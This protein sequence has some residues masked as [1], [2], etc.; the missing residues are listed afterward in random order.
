MG[1]RVMSAAMLAVLVGCADEPSSPATGD[2]VFHGGPVLTI[3]DG[4]AEAL[5]VRG[6]R[7]LAVGT[8]DQVLRE[9]RDPRRVDLGGAALLPGFI[10]GHT[11]LV[12]QPGRQG[13]SE[14]D[15]I[16]TALRLGITTVAET[17]GWQ[18]YVD[19]LLALEAGGELRVRVVFYPDYNLSGPGEEEPFA[20]IGTWYPANP[21]LVDDGRRLRISGI[22][23]FVDG[24]FSENRGC[25]ALTDPYPQEAQDDPD[26][27]CPDP[28]GALL[29]EAAPLADVLVAAEEAG[30]A[31]AMHAIGDRALDHAL[32]ALEQARARTG[33]PPRPHQL[34]HNFF[35]RPDQMQRYLDLDV[36]FSVWAYAHTCNAEVHRYWFG[37]ERAQW[38]ANRFAL[39]RTG[40]RGFVESDFSWRSLPEDRFY[41]RP[42]DPLVLLWAL[43]THRENRH[44][45]ICEPEPWLAD[46]SV[47][48]ELALR[49]YT[50]N[51][52]Y[53]HGID[54][55]VGSLRPGK[56][57]D[58]VVLSAD[59]TI[60][61]P[62]A[63][64]DIQ[65]LLTMVDGRVEYCA[66]SCPWGSIS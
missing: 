32:D 29:I 36:P 49:M 31:V 6:D 65:V 35:M 12:R 42:V 14:R 62:D 27:P 38:W 43:V 39:A 7:I 21:P 66:A 9:A 26:F 51:A 40:G 5:A 15:A 44:G 53:A 63:I 37:A 50:L 30:Y 16:D 41:H 52:A 64:P 60:V 1:C 58:L 56:R 10:D 3:E 4:V 18:E 19:R 24:A 33:G 48:I 54:H 2:I 11:H 13:R 45:E 55:L 57:A 61:A 28:R 22:K 47:D 23:I 34:H 25:Y 20:Y 17:A 59:P 8:L 46:Q